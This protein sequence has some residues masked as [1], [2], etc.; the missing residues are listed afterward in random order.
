MN[1]ALINLS[2]VQSRIRRSRST[3]YNEMA[4]GI[5]PRPLKIGRRC[6]WR[7]DEVEDLIAAYAADAS[8]A[9]LSRLCEEFYERRRAR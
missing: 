2:E 5:F 3:L 4:A 6:F 1:F 8:G 9:D 7:D